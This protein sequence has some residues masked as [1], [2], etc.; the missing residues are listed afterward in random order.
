MDFSEIIMIMLVYG[1]LFL[2]ALQMVS[3]K[4]KMVGF[5]K[6]AILIIL[7]GFISTT[8]WL[9]YKAEEYHINN[10]SGYEPISFTH[11]A[12]LMIV[13]LS[14]YSV[15]LFSLSILLKKSRYS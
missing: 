1:G 12:I 11:H 15:V 3:S 9:T 7:F 6:S 5:V 14:I 13:G 2:Y 8:I 4:N 10:H